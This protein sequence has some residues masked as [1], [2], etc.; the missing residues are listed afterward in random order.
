MAVEGHVLLAVIPQAVG[1]DDIDRVFLALDG[2]LLH[3]GQRLSPSHRNG[4]DLERLE[5]RGVNLVFH[6][7]QLEAGEIVGAR[8]RANGVGHVAEAALGVSQTLQPRVLQRIQQLAADFA[9]EHLVSLF[10]VGEQV[11]HIQ[12]AHRLREVDE[13]AAGDDAHIQHAGAHGIEHVALAAQRAVRI[14]LN[15]IFAVRALVHKLGEFYGRH[16]EAVLL[17]DRGA[18]LQS[19]FGQ[20][21]CAGHRQRQSGGGKGRQFLHGFLLRKKCC[22]RSPRRAI[23]HIV[24]V[25]KRMSTLFMRQ[26]KNVHVSK[27]TKRKR[28]P[29]TS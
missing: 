24:L 29:P 8:H 22:S 12:H 15:L 11:R 17:V 2:A 23:E 19:R 16:V 27:R 26:M 10:V 5:G 28:T 9:V 18:Q 20:R 4:V 6:H 13:R 7:A 3:G 1:I 25:L 21:A 14:N